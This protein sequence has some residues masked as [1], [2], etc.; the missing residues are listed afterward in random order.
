MRK[1]LSFILLIL[2]ITTFI[3][4]QQQDK[5]D[6]QSDIKRIIQGEFASV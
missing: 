2:S 4:T 6:S 5:S 3:F 1:Q